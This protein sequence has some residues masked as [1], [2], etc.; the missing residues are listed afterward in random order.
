[1][2]GSKSPAKLDAS[3]A[4]ICEGEVVTSKPLGGTGEGEVETSKPLAVSGGE[5]NRMLSTDRL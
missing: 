5:L 4:G 3:L 1:M 2:R